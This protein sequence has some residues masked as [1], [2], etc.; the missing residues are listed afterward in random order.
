MGASDSYLFRFPS[1]APHTYY[2][3]KAIKQHCR[4]TNLA[5]CL[6]L[7]TEGILWKDM[8]ANDGIEEFNPAR[9]KVKKEPLDPAEEGVRGSSNNISLHSFAY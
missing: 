3:L 4:R 5:P 9:M 2:T 8:A 6:A 7:L 1:P